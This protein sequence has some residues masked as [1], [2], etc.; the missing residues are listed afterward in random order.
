MS[1][2]GIKLGVLAWNQYTS[3][4]AMRDVA[5]RADALGYDD[6]W[7][8]DHLYPIVGSHEG[9]MLEGWLLLA[10][11]AGVTERARL[12]L[13]VGANTFRNS[14]TSP[15][16]APSWASAGRGSRRSTAPSASSSGL[17]PASG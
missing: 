15:A 1:E 2:A 5:Q 13:M 9:P 17:R 12:G 3:W 8:W 16:G 11:W 4:D 10:A 6:V 14:T 7:T